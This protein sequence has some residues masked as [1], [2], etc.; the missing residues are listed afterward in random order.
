MNNLLTSIPVEFNRK[1]QKQLEKTGANKLLVA[2]SG[3]LDST[4]LL[5]LVSDFSKCNNLDC[6]ALHV[7][8]QLSSNASEWAA[9]CAEFCREC[10]IPIEV[11][12]VQVFSASRTSLEAQ[13]REARYGALQ[14]RM[15]EKTLLLTGQ[16]RDDQV[17]TLLLQL[18]RGSGPKGLAAMPELKSF[19]AG[20]I[21]RPLLSLSREQL[22]KWAV[23]VGLTWIEDESNE[24]MAF[25]RNFLRHQIV[26][27]MKQRWPG[28]DKAISRSA[29]LCAESQDLLD[30]LAQI[31]VGNQSLI[32]SLPL[33]VLQ[34]LPLERQRN[35]LRFWLSKQNVVMPPAIRLN[36]FLTQVVKVKPDRHPEL[37]WQQRKLVV[38]AH[39]LYLI[40]L[41]PPRSDLAS[42][43]VS[44]ESVILP[45]GLGRIKIVEATYSKTDPLLRLE[46]PGEKVS[47][48]FGV[49]SVRSCP[50]KRVGY[51]SLSKR[52]H[53]MH[54]PPWQRS[55]VPLVFFGEQLAA[56]GDFWI[57][58]GFA[59]TYG[60]PGY[61]I[62]WERKAR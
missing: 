35:L 4:V 59:V 10:H 32:G 15:D 47:I 19:A 26:P 20:W 16:H 57:E 46:V 3:G 23:H 18:K 7:N 1:I 39:A 12:T 9:H 29:E 50:D 25:D 36:N 28:V 24:S 33:S 38:Y 13:A 8:H 52:M 61:Q 6:T 43:M 54:I 40:P 34:G 27:L 37:R 14:Q 53:E 60:K 56:V 49:Q 21:G 2:F 62:T 11:M 45:Q 17:E 42:I 30:Q 51:R 31:D 44:S 58:K 22:E 48:R 41:L 5:T 55:R